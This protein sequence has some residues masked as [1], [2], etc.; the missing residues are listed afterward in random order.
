M[1]SVVAEASSISKAVELAWQ[2]AGQPKEF[3]VKVFQEPQRNMFGL[4]KTSAKVGIFFD[5]AA[6]TQKIKNATQSTIPSSQNNKT[7]NPISPIKPIATRPQAPK[8]PAPKPNKPQPKLEPVVNSPVVEPVAP[9]NQPEVSAKPIAESKPVSKSRPEV[10][11]ANQRRNSQPNRP[12]QNQPKPQ[13]TNQT[14]Q[15]AVNTPELKTS[16][17]LLENNLPAN[18]NAVSSDITQPAPRPARNKYYRRRRPKSNRPNT[19]EG[20]E[21]TKPAA[22]APTNKSED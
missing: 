15:A 9:T 8:Q 6:L 13:A 3:L 5:D 16:D 18:V 7:V 21:Q 2:K 17:V 4:T 11:P 14:S 19:G 1:K 10:R 22:A 20:G 12:A